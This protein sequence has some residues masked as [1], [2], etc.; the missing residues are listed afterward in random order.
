MKNLLL[1]ALLLTLPL[2]LGGCGEKPVAET[3]TIEEAP[4]NSIKYKVT[5][6]EVAITDY[7]IEA[8][9]EL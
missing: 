8:S 2:L 4:I 6:D 3:K 7:D 1:F 9:V 5:G